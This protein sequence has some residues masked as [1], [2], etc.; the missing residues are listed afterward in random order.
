M[1]ELYSLQE[2][3]KALGVTRRAVQGYEKAG[4][5]SATDRNKYG[6]LRYGVKEQER[7]RK[8]KF[9]Q[10]LGFKIRDIKELIDAPNN[11]VKEALE[12][13]VLELEKEQN[14]LDAL[15]KEARQLIRQ[16]AGEQ[17]E[18]YNE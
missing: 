13:Q 14:K 10:Q 2:I 5:V 18:K 17:E 6:H 11:F 4:L 9:F 16:L 1:N 12:R 8:I 15:I 7:I 3:C